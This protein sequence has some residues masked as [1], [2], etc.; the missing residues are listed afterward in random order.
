MQ[1]LKSSEA[2]ENRRRIFRCSAESAKPPR[3]PAKVKREEPQ[4]SHRPCYPLFWSSHSEQGAQQQAQ[5]KASR[6]NLVPLGEIFSSLERG[7]AH[8]AFV[9]DVLEAAF[10]VHPALAQKSLARLALNGTS[11]AMKSFS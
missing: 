4:A 10:Q 11:S 8:S 5:V 6:R 7:A 2:Y 1:G 9:K 3:L